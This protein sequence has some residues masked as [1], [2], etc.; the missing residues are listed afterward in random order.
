MRRDR[1]RRLVA[2]VGHAPALWLCYRETISPNLV[3]SNVIAAT[4]TLAAMSAVAVT[5]PRGKAALPVAGVWLAGHL[6]W[7]A[8]LAS[9]LPPSQR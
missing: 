2:F 9:R 5:R 4:A 7:G 1:L 8:Y 6:L 3:R